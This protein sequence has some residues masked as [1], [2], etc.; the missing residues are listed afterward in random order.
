MTLSPRQRIRAGVALG[1]LLVGLATAYTFRNPWFHGNF[2]VVDA[3][4]A[5]RS[6]QP[7]AGLSALIDERGIKTVLNLRGG[8]EADPWY[9]AE[10]DVTKSKG[11]AFYDL[12]M[13][14]TA[15]P[16]R[17][18]LLTLVDLFTRCDTPILIHC[19]SGSDRTGLAS[20]LYRMVVLGEPPETAVAAFSLHYGH[21]P[22]L[23]TRHLHE[24]FDEYAA[25][26]TE[27]KRTHQPETFRSWVEHEYRAEDPLTALVPLAPGPRPRKIARSTEA[28]SQQ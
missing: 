28:E 4:K 13:T 15:R 6:A 11:V 7:L 21:V 22:L 26:L 25:W 17:K 8:S 16:T 5:Y 18:Q 9:A 10:V 2:G 27:T 19:K 23:G 20:A 1:L 3:G 24:P 14:A 12:P